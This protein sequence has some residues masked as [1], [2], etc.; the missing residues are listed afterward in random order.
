MLQS[1]EHLLILK[2]AQTGCQELIF[3]FF[4]SSHVS[5]HKISVRGIIP[6]VPLID[7]EFIKE[8]HDS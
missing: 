2:M 7:Q 1:F 6:A 8:L 5:G 3:P 4:L